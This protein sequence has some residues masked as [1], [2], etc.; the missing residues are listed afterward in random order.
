MLSSTDLPRA[1]YELTRS[2]RA[3]DY[4]WKEDTRIGDPFEFGELA[5]RRNDLG[6]WDKIREAAIKNDLGSIPADIYI[7]YYNNLTRIAADHAQPASMVRSATVFWGP[8]GTGK[9]RR[10]WELAGDSAYSKDPRTKFWCGY[11]GQDTVVIDEFRGGIDISHLLRWLDRYPVRVERKGGS[12]PL[13]ATTFYITSNLSPNQWYPELDPETKLA[14]TR[15][16]II[17]YID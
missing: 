16:L 4:V 8:T 2:K 7:R 3:R 6:D 1:H 11:K 14:L 13:M 17:E 12:A 10:A 15:R 9:S 5:I